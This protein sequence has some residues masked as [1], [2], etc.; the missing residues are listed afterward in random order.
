MGKS[1]DDKVDLWFMTSHK[2]SPLPPPPFFYALDGKSLP[3]L[4]GWSLATCRV[5]NSGPEGYVFCGLLSLPV[6]RHWSCFLKVKV[7]LF[8]QEPNALSLYRRMLSMK[9][10]AYLMN[11]CNLKIKIELKKL[12]PFEKRKE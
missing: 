1:Q 12:V 7:C 2:A 6:T 9:Y 3:I 4:M 5:T 8:S 10:P 11:K